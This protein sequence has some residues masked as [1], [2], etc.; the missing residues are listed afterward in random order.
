MSKPPLFFIA[1]VVLIAVLATR[2]YLNKRRE[3]AENDR[4]P[5]RSL[6]VEVSAKREFPVP[7]RRSRQRE[8]IVAEDMRYEVYFRPLL[9]GSEIKMPLS[10][11][12]Y[13]QIDKGT[14]GTL[15][16]QGT[17]FISFTV[18]PQP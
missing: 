1:V 2:Q 3:D 14:Q 5:V 8:N 12:Q 11:Q 15:S 7:N 17:R 4:S 18:K 10:Q 16:L 9:G 6:Q 13:Q